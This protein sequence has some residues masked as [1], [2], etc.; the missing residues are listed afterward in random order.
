MIKCF[1]ELKRKQGKKFPECVQIYMGQNYLDGYY[2]KS[3]HFIFNSDHFS[4]NRPLGRFS[5]LVAMSVC[6]FVCLA[7]DHKLLVF[8][9]FR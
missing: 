4:L 5:L 6:V 2:A 1:E 7:C 3:G 8:F 9:L